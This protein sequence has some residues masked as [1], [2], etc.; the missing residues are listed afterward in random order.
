VQPADSIEFRQE[1]FS[2]SKFALLDGSTD[3]IP[4]RLSV[5][6]TGNNVTGVCMIF[7]RLLL[8]FT[9]VPLVELWLLL[10]ISQYTGPTL[11]ILLVIGTGIAGAALARRQGWQTWSRIQAQLAQGQ[12]PTGSLLDGMMILIAGALLITPGV[13]T[14]L[15]GFALL[16]PA[17]RDVLRQ[18]LGRWIK[19][20]ATVQYQSMQSNTAGGGPHRQDASIIEAEVVRR[21]GEE[22]AEDR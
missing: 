9:I 3:E 22:Q 7:L 10:A 17:I 18:R 21:P 20:R 5:V 19:T 4:R 12:P 13:L 15:V 6:R 8:L 11:T 2:A 14:D 16:V 1:S